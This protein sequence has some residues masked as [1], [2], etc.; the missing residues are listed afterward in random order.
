MIK[1]EDLIRE[2]KILIPKIQRDYAQGRAK[3]SKSGIEITSEK[4]Y[5]VR[6]GL[7]NS[8][9]EGVN[10]KVRVDLNF[11]YGKKDQIDGKDIFIPIDGQQRL[12]TLFL[13][14]WYIYQRA[15]ILDDVKR[16]GDAFSYDTRDT[17][18][19]FC[20]ELCNKIFVGDDTRIN[21]M[22]SAREEE[23][24][25]Y[26]LSSQIK[27]M[28]WFTSNYSHD[29]SVKSMLTML[30][31]IEEKFVFSGLYKEATKFV[32]VSEWLKSS[33]CTIVFTYLDVQDFDDQDMYI[34]MNAR[35]KE[36]TNFEIFKARLEEGTILSGVCYEENDTPEEKSQKIANFVGKYNNEFTNL[37]YGMP[38][39]GKENYDAA[40]FRFVECILKYDHYAWLSAKT[41]ISEDYYRY[42]ISNSI[43]SGASLFN[44]FI[45]H[46]SLHGYKKDDSSKI[47]DELR[48]KSK[49]SLLKITAILDFL[50]NNGFDVFP[51]YKNTIEKLTPFDEKQLFCTNAAPS[52]SIKNI[53]QYALFSFLFY[54]D[55]ENDFSSKE[56]AYKEWKRFVC[57]VTY[58]FKVKDPANFAK[59]VGVFDCLLNQVHDVYM[60]NGNSISS[61]DVLTV[62]R[63]YNNISEINNM[64][65]EVIRYLFE[66]EARKA[67][68]ILDQNNG[69]EWSRVIRDAEDYYDDGNV[70]FIFEA[71]NDNIAPA[72]FEKIFI[73][74]KE[75]INGNKYPKDEVV[76][77]QAL[78]CIDYKTENT[79]MAHLRIY[80]YDWVWQLFLGK[81]A[82][83]RDA[84][85]NGEKG[86]ANGVKYGVISLL[87]QYDSKQTPGEFTE[88]LI[89][90]YKP[91]DDCWLRNT[92]ISERITEKIEKY[93]SDWSYSGSIGRWSQ[94]YPDEYV[95]FASTAYNSTNL[96]FNTYRLAV[97]LA[98]SNHDVSIETISGKPRYKNR[99]YVS[100]NGRKVSY[101][102][103]QHLFYD[104]DNQKYFTEVNSDKGM[105]EAI[106]YLTS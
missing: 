73:K 56:D 24:S 55:C 21:N 33:D 104:I 94:N 96:E 9:F 67:T 99:R 90:N 106:K 93:K 45:L 87:K 43:Y 39:I 62:I 86:P 53:I 84:L 15:N 65:M 29:P 58:R 82:D 70:D 16:L 25:I 88:N 22:L 72:E 101:D 12:T 97:K 1:F 95:L 27:D 20:K 51:Y 31:T 11:V 5:Q 48:I 105:E 38:E 41:D 44:E 57:N 78:L 46:P 54:T 81:Q 77:N 6:M 32:E 85:I 79:E 76:F 64:A 2:N 17:T 35:G 75:W 63:D 103:E 36:L 19:E 71:I 98:D 52:S 49:S 69:A 92:L 83:L 30:D 8:L 80:S 34:K 37:F 18:R 4:P 10:D 7:V 100:L 59:M 61:N 40:F 26:K 91:I 68:L 74:S 14:H 3:Y 102:I 23:K 28:I 89:K 13:F 66:S 47:V 50:V 42:N 60:N